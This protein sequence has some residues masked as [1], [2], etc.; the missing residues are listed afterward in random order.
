MRFHFHVRTCELIE[1]LEGAE[2][3]DEAEALSEVRFSA[4]ELLGDG[5]LGRQ[6]RD[7]WRIEVADAMG[8]E[9]ANLS[10]AEATRVH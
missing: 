9:I 3:A 10:L 5:F 4:M 6:N 2:F 1:D 8:N 7:N